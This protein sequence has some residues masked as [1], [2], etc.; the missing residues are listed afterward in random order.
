MRTVRTYFLSASCT[1]CNCFC[2]GGVA[3]I[4]GKLSKTRNRSN[5]NINFHVTQRPTYYTTTHHRWPG[6]E[7]CLDCILPGFYLM[8]RFYIRILQSPCCARWG[9][10]DKKL[11]VSERFQSCSCNQSPIIISQNHVNHWDHCNHGNLQIKWPASGQST[12]LW[13][14]FK[15]KNFIQK[16][17][18]TN[19][20]LNVINL[21][22][23]LSVDSN[24]CRQPYY[25][26]PSPWC[27][28]HPF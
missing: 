2:L 28:K 18:S 26:S 12:F 3:V 11:D 22:F 1:P 20:N 21:T 25:I 23:W 10:T 19:N 7:V 6:I 9:P 13:S 27:H 17:F 15:L 8:T 5:H 14:N 4:C 16:S 24:E